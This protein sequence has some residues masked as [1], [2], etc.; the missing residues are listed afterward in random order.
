MSHQ[1]N[2]KE[3]ADCSARETEQDERETLSQNH[4][5]NRGATRTERHA[6]ADLLCSLINRKREHAANS[7]SGNDEREQGEETEKTRDQ[8]R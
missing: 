2:E 8:F 1:P 3:R 6:N 4:F 7:C 5:Q